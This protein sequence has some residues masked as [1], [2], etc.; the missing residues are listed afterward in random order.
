MAA[1]DTR[2]LPAPI[3]L[4]KLSQ[5]NSFMKILVLRGADPVAIADVVSLQLYEATSTESP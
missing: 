4:P 5:P 2:C 1:C 3:P